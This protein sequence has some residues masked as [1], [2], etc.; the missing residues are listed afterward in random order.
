VGNLKVGV[1][2]SSAKELEI[3]VGG[4]VNEL[5]ICIKNEGK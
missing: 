2:N 5:N 3:S 4:N 1:N